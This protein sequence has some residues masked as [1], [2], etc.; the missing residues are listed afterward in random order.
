MSRVLLADPHRLISNK[1]LL[2]PFDVVDFT[3]S[4]G[5]RKAKKKSL[6]RH[7]RPC[8]YSLT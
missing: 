3:C 7:L 1:L 4:H 5:L 8:F 6:N 2:F